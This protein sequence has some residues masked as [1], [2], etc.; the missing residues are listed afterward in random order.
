MDLSVSTL[1]DAGL[2]ILGPADIKI[3]IKKLLLININNYHNNISS[4]FKV[5]M[6]KIHH[7]FFLERVMVALNLLKL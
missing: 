4:F 5:S 1:A 3:Q 7:V 6:V 2:S